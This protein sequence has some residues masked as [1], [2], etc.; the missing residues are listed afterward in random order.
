MKKLLALLLT[1]CLVIGMVPLAASAEGEGTITV[2]PGPNS[3]ESQ[4]YTSLADALS[5]VNTM[6]GE[7][8]ITILLP[9][10][11]FSPTANEQFKITH[12]NVTLEGAGVDKTII[13]Y[14]GYSCSGQGGLIISADNVTVQDL[15]VSST[16]ETIDQNV[17][18]IK[19]TDIVSTTENWGPVKNV[20]L[21]NVKLSSAK[22]HALNLHGVEEATI[23]HVDAYEETILGAIYGNKEGGS[24]QC[25]REPPSLLVI[26][27]LEVVK[28]RWNG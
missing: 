20:T 27:F 7:E 6:T 28:P 25:C 13:D 15:T 18:A 26:E 8:K 23:D 10:G 2:K 1:L 9:E 14:Q 12:D 5:A 19:V 16:D 17:A 4:T 24:R 21:K 3:E 22:G 11:T